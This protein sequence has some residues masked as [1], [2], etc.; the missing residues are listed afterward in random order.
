MATDEEIRQAGFKYI[1]QQKFNFNQEEK[2]I[3]FQINDEN[4]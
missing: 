2:S 3:S 1:P 4:E